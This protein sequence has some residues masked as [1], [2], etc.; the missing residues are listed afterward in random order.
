MSFLSKIA[1]RVFGTLP[2]IGTHMGI[3]AELLVA[4]L[5]PLGWLHVPGTG[6]LSDGTPV[7][8][9]FTE[10]AYADQMLLNEAIKSGRLIFRDVIKREQIN[11]DLSFESTVR[12]Y[13]QPWNHENLN[14]MAEWTSKTFNREPVTGEQPDD[15]K[16]LGYRKRDRLLWNYMHKFP[17]PF[18]HAIILL[19]DKITRDAYQANEL[20]KAHKIIGAQ[21]ELK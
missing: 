1:N 8:E 18:Q 2:V 20:A 5:K 3:E 11:T 13:A 7:N 16:M 12:L 4:G 6:S 17:R 15:G 9:K 19:N 21:Y 10:K 14:L